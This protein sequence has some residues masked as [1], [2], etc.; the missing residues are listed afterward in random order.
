MSTDAQT[1]PT[2]KQG[3]P[4]TQAKAPKGDQAPAV[5]NAPPSRT[6]PAILFGVAWAGWI[7]F[8]VCMVAL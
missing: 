8:L 5:G 6:A 7:V 1:A 3:S 4:R 2:G